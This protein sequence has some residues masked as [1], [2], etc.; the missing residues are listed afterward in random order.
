MNKNFFQ[1]KDFKLEKRLE[2][3][4]KAEKD[5]NSLGNFKDLESGNGVIGAKGFIYWLV[6]QL[7]SG[8]KS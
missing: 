8:A 7:K 5:L 2:D 4:I 3:S 1:L 6:Q